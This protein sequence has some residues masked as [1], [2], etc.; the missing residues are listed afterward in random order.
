MHSAGGT[1]IQHV[2]NSACRIGEGDRFF[3]F[4]TCGWMMEL[5]GVRPCAGCHVVA[6][7]R[8]AIHPDGNVIFDFAQDEKM[9]HFGT[10][11]KFI[12]SVRKADLRPIETHD[13]RAFA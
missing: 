4:T 1:L 9:T 10:S 3:Y 6:L 13:L 5:V 2:R 8:L 7:R 12:D 11:A